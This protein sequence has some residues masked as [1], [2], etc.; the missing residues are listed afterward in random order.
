M[1]QPDITA[2]LTEELH[3][4]A[5]EIDLD[6]IDRAEDLREELDID[7][8]D[9]LTLVT[10]LG[11]RLGLEMPEADYDQMRSFDAMVQY[12]RAKSA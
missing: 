8:M 5:P 9:F 12:L 7:S 6:D 4:I 1:T 2:L 10:A 3:R 11:K